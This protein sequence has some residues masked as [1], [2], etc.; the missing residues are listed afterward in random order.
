MENR[1]SLPDNA[2]CHTPG[3]CCAILAAT[4]LA[5]VLS[6]CA[7][8]SRTEVGARDR[9]EADRDAGTIAA[10]LADRLQA[11]SLAADMVLLSQRPTIMT[12]SPYVSSLLVSDPVYGDP[13]YLIVGS[14]ETELAA[15]RLFNSAGY[16]RESRYHAENL[17]AFYGPWLDMQPALKAEVETSLLSGNE[18][19]YDNDKIG[20]RSSRLKELSGRV[21]KLRERPESGPVAS[22]DSADKSGSEKAGTARIIVA[23]QLDAEARAEANAVLAEC[24]RFL[25]E[26]PRSSPLWAHVACLKAEV[27]GMFGRFQDAL[28]DLAAV[29]ACNLE[30]CHFSA[31]RVAP[32]E[33]AGNNIIAAVERYYSL[34]KPCLDKQLSGLV[35]EGL[36]TEKELRDPWGRPFVADPCNCCSCDNFPH[37]R[38]FLSLGPD[39]QA[40]TPDDIKIGTKDRVLPRAAKFE[41]VVG[42]ALVRTTQA[43]G[44][45]SDEP[46]VDH[47]VEEEFEVI[48]EDLDDPTSH[49]PVCAHCTEDSRASLGG[50]AQ[51][52]EDLLRDLKPSMPAEE[53]EP[54]VLDLANR[55]AYFGKETWAEA[56]SVLCDWQET[57]SGEVALRRVMLDAAASAC[58]VKL[59][60]AQPPEP[61]ELA[62]QLR[63][64]A[65]E[66]ASP[67]SR[68]RALVAAG[69]L[70][71]GAGRLDEAR[72][73]FA[74]ARESFKK[75]KASGQ[76]QFEPHD[77]LAALCEH[78]LLLAGS[79]R[80]LLE[81]DHI[82]ARPDEPV[83]VV[84]T[85]ADRRPIRLRIF[86]APIELREFLQWTAHHGSEG[87]WVPSAMAADLREERLFLR[88]LQSFLD[89]LDLSAQ[90]VIREDA[91]GWPDDRGKQ[92][93]MS[94]ALPDTGAYVAEFTTSAESSRR[95]LLVVMPDL[96]IDLA[97]ASSLKLVR[98]CEPTSGKPV[99]GV[100][101]AGREI[102]WTR[103]DKDPD[104]WV[105]GV[106]GEEKAFP[107][108]TDLNGILRLLRTSKV[109]E[110]GKDTKVGFYPNEAGLVEA[111][112]GDNRLLLSSESGLRRVAERSIH[113]PNA[114]G[115]LGAARKTT[116]YLYTDRPVY[117]AGQRVFFKG[118]VRQEK[119]EFGPEDTGRYELPDSR[120]T[121][122][123]SA[124]GP[125]GT[126]FCRDFAV[127]RILDA[128]TPDDGDE[129][130][131]GPS[132]Q[133]NTYGS[134]SGR[135]P[136]SFW[137]SIDLP[138]ET[139]RGAITL[140]V[141][142]LGLSASARVK[143]IDF[144]KSDYKL[145]F[146]GNDS[147]DVSASVQ[148]AWGMPVAGATLR[149]HV[150]NT[151]A[152]GESVVGA[153]G[154]AIIAVGKTVS[155]GKVCAEVVREGTVVHSGVY[156][157]S[158]V[159]P[160]E[161]AVKARLVSS[162][163]DTHRFEISC[164]KADGTPVESGRLLIVKL[165]D[166][167]KEP[168]ALRGAEPIVVEIANGERCAVTLFLDEV[169]VAGS[170][171]EA[172]PS[173]A[174]PDQTPAPPKDIV[175]TTDKKDY[176]A[177]EKATITIRSTI[178][179]GAGVL[180][181]GDEHIYDVLPF[182]LAE[183]TAAVE[184]TLKDL[185]AARVFA[186]AQVVGEGRALAGSVE[187][188]V[189]SGLRIG[190]RP[191]VA[192]P[193]PK[194][195]IEL[196]VETKDLL[197]K[198][199][200]AEVSLGIV[201]DRIYRFG[202]ESVTA[203]DKAFRR[204]R[205]NVIQWRV[206]RTIDLGSALSLVG[207]VP[208]GRHG[209]LL[210]GVVTPDPIVCG[211][212]GGG[213]GR[214]G[215]RAGGGSRHTYGGGS[216]E[217]PVRIEFP[218]TALWVPAMETD[219]NGLRT[220]QFKVPDSI[221]TYRM[222]LR[223]IT[224]DGVCGEARENLI[225]KQD[226]FVNLYCPQFFIA[227]DKGAVQAQVFN[228][229][230][231]ELES[232]VRLEGEGFDQDPARA[233]RKLTIAPSGSAIVEWP[234]QVTS[235]GSV[236]FKA[237]ARG[238]VSKTDDATGA[239]AVGFADAI[240]LDVP[241]KI[242]GEQVRK[243]VDGELDAGETT[244]SVHLPPEAEPETARLEVQL[245]PFKGEMYGLL[246]TVEF[247]KQFPY[248]C[249]E[250]TMSKFLPNIAVSDIFTKLKVS[251]GSYNNE[252]AAMV[253]EGTNRLYNFQKDDGGWGWFGSDPTDPFMTA[254]VVYGLKTAEAHG[255]A[256][257]P[258]RLKK[259]VDCLKAMAAKEEDRNK[260]AYMFYVLSLC[261]TEPKADGFEAEPAAADTAAAVDPAKTAP[262]PDVVELE[263][264]L[265]GLSPYAL[266]CRALEFN[267]NGKA[268]DAQRALR[269][270]EAA[271]ISDANGTHW[272]TADW[273]YKWEQVD[274]ETT[275][276]V[277]K[278][279]VALDPE[280]RLIPETVRWLLARRQGNKWGST[281]DTAA[282]IMALV[283]YFE[284]SDGSL[285]ALSKAMEEGAA[286]QR[287]IAQAG[288]VSLN[289]KS[290]RKL[291]ADLAS[292]F[293][294]RTYQMFDARELEPGANT[295]KFAIESLGAAGG[296][297]QVRP[298]YVARLCYTRDFA[299]IC[300]AE[301]RKQAQQPVS[302][303]IEISAAVQLP[304]GKATRHTEFAV[305]LKLV[306]AEDCDFVL[307]TSP[308]PAGCA[309]VS[310]S[311]QGTFTF[312]EARDEKAV[313]FLRSV[314]K[315]EHHLKYVLN[316]RFTGVYSVLA[317]EAYMM[318][319]ETIRGRGA[320]AQVT[321][322]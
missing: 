284:K 256:V 31:V 135:S 91:F 52:Y 34:R 191:S 61:L 205:N 77:I 41:P 235:R 226:F 308:I 3:R 265:A 102:V 121:A 64:V 289:G 58:S 62:R 230:P 227:G 137:G 292:P 111:G 141:E 241:V 151:D 317:P 251:P 24:S 220:V 45:V 92:L 149:Y 312:F 76:I 131:A 273:Y 201:D 97:E 173:V 286:R 72:T 305:D 322:E 93:E 162:Q 287:N 42:R 299:R 188:P 156:A 263:P 211:M 279:V 183:G 164:A 123:V 32:V 228:F 300:D 25:S 231:S 55:L 176:V 296:L 63:A 309:I 179:R 319:D 81:Q 248:G 26:T 117:R 185:Y 15:C 144:V 43:A 288:T 20:D 13:V 225:V 37:C 157:F 229:T 186:V 158:C 2:Q 54:F 21:A 275:A 187:V 271:A 294:A 82:V 159:R 10:P 261:K 303:G 301:V 215:G 219:D 94:F 147:G 260:L 126:I 255:Y 276:Y 189:N 224:A 71:Y 282:A 8:D 310:G 182:E 53:I 98:V 100:T 293:E 209:E 195:E 232:E 274:V 168:R 107:G 177:G 277:L 321:I 243:V 160:D 252:L 166:G 290:P 115:P 246:E 57:L 262:T 87:S 138:Q 118:I 14:P 49:L 130:T 129:E 9:T 79:S 237:T 90:A 171:F 272:E 132:Q 112:S 311:E 46:L 19:V 253:A 69:K 320:A 50:Y 83:R 6:T 180:V 28:H 146:A 153:D 267:N 247:L 306:A 304:D 165:N 281:K 84:A 240:A 70:L 270:L 127:G 51:A 106:P 202:E 193:R 122:K 174:R 155:S 283:T 170:T 278:A 143:V 169:A 47:P 163:A 38:A 258:E 213:G 66:S 139:P 302:H 204:N 11:C 1:R 268:E 175:L 307:V 114:P 242:A 291:A 17:A 27:L 16:A 318:Y 199:R 266:A 74:E 197:G 108:A 206:Y 133:G 85:S 181:I 249:V 80:T 285:K 109:S 152:K 119:N 250:Q 233:L 33:I 239:D 192:V 150:L 172:P 104:T 145:E 120:F 124:K 65:A 56:R 194:D 35:K 30:H 7:G 60:D 142:C 316:P 73:A 207:D 221:T 236:R 218:D 222:N 203:I 103:N 29:P 315:G 264:D 96:R 216:A 68:F 5:L 116:V 12:E 4:A 214:F 298:G 36:L 269:L 95:M 178:L 257:D 78:E 128:A 105:P 184:A 136:G 18:V 200:S 295:M 39:G 259:G 148:Y 22:D 48:E 217:P 314:P 198:P 190:I 67:L 254:Y 59:S 161:F 297:A 234:I 212:S 88:A 280:N 134:A 223:G 210:L 140:T 23:R 89:K 86:P 113:T 208:A 167:R 196:T 125:G 238:R 244:V 101:L 154:R 313:F 75:E 40:G 245:L 44:D 99:A 110:D